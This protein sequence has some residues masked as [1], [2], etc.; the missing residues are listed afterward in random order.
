MFQTTN[1]IICG[2]RVS[3]PAIF[4]QFHST[5]PT[6]LKGL[7]PI[8]PATQKTE[9]RKVLETENFKPDIYIYV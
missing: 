4:Q 5:T 1:E 8:G 7:I 6:D 3:V 9:R 2:N